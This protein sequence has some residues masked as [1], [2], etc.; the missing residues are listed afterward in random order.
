MFHVG[1]EE[2]R[3]GGTDCMFKVLHLSCQHKNNMSGGFCDTNPQHLLECSADSEDKETSIR[4]P[5]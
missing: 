3:R 4:S 1:Q 5:S 2:A